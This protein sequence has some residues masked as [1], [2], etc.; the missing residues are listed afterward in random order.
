V[1]RL[2]EGDVRGLIADL[3]VWEQG[4][5][6][7]TGLGLA[8]LAERACDAD[9]GAAAQLLGARIGVVPISAGLGYIPGFTQCVAAILSHLGGDAFVTPRP[10]VL[11]WQ[12]AAEHGAE[13]VFAADDYRFIALNIHSGT[14][15]DN[16]PATAAGYVAALAAA[17][18][19]AGK[20]VLVIG[21]GPVGRAAARR[22]DGLGAQVLAA[23]IDRGRAQ[24]AE[25]ELNVRLVS[26]DEGL[27]ACDLVVDATPVAD[28]IPVGWVGEHS[29]VVAPGLPPAATEA[30]RTALGDRHVHDP[31]AVGVAVM[32]LTALIGSG[33]AVPPTN[34]V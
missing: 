18:P 2:T 3:L 25:Q 23:E 19:V 7:L 1:T 16:D 5:R 4:L 28:L 27:A 26:L 31:L 6:R 22:L 30:A 29:F 11:G 15:V 33:F 32:A 14:C 13:I 20:P 21:L 12:H 24:A 9:A 8:G 34:A 10:D 17:A